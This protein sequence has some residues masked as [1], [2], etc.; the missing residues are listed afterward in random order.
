MPSRLQHAM[1]KAPTRPTSEIDAAVHPAEDGRDDLP[2]LSS[3]SNGGRGAAGRQDRPLGFPQDH[4]QRH[5]HGAKPGLVRTGALPHPEEDEV[6]PL[7]RRSAP[8]PRYPSTSTVQSWN[9]SSG[10]LTNPLTRGERARGARSKVI[11][12]NAASSCM[13]ICCAC[14]YRDFRFSGSCSAAA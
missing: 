12:M 7:Q 13:M 11:G 6:G 2:S 3:P 1:V 8:A 10:G 9:Q 14:W 4:P 5:R